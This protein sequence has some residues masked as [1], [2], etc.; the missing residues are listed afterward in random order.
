M[1]NFKKEKLSGEQLKSVKGGT[2]TTPLTPRERCEMKFGHYWDEGS[3]RCYR[4]GDGYRI[5]NWA[6]HEQKEPTSDDDNGQG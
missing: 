1:K 4:E 5:D 6:W 3:K 2:I